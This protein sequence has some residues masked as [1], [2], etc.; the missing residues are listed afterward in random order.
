MKNF[1]SKIVKRMNTS[2]TRWFEILK[3]KGIGP[4]SMIVLICLGTSAFLGA[5]VP[6][7]I[8]ELSRTYDD[9][10]LFKQSLINLSIIFFAVYAN[11]A[12]YQIGVNKFIKL[13]VRRVRNFCYQKWLLHYD[14]QSS[15]DK[16]TEAFPQGE[17]LAR[18][19]NDTES[20]RELIT[21][22]TFGIFIDLFF[23]ISCLVSFLKINLIS[24]GFLMVVEVLA[25]II[26]I[27]LSK[28]MRA[29]F[30]S[31]RNARGY[32]SRAVANV[33]G[34]ISETHY[35]DHQ[36]YASK[37]CEKRFTDF[38]NKQLVSN[39]WDAGYYS[40]AES[41]YPMLLACVVFIFPYSKITEVAV[42][43]AIVD[44]IQRSIGPIKDI[45]GKIANVQR[46]MT[47]FQRIG[48]FINH[49]EEGFFSE[50]RSALGESVTFD[51]LEV[52][53]DHFQYFSTKGQSSF[54]L[55]DIHF[56]GEKGELIGLVGLSGS[57]KSTLLNILAANIIPDKADIRLLSGDKSSVHSYPGS[58]AMDVVRYREQIGIVSQE[59]HVF[60]ETLAFNITL[61]DN[62]PE[63]FEKFWSWVEEQIPYFVE[64]GIKSDTLINPSEL[65]SGQKQLIAAVRS[66]YLKKTIVLFDE[67]SSGLD[68][69][70][71]AALR[72]VVLLVQQNSLTIIVAHRVETIID[73]DKIL[74][75]DDG[76]LVSMGRHHDLLQSSQTYAQFLHE[77]SPSEAN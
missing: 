9:L 24:G 62:I 25:S 67:I 58:G 55:S 42:I 28:Y 35:T 74:V 53:I 6:G 2:L 54:S 48:G 27:W 21:S 75:M 61:S 4:L 34:G 14:V 63:D 72:K 38:L 23:V 50:K 18:I 19:M 37:N 71:E 68:G 17:V 32:M 59:S 69:A 66:C 10:D 12:I 64:W 44:L 8:A 26:L 5:K 76:K 49:L 46:A 3:F 30:L 15:K 22:G 77:L 1:F 16:K 41:L 33:V 20:F 39:V 73:A 51:Q 43:F 56:V 40:L 29:I 52:N 31:V 13:L 65:S 60:S 70:L 11:R 47:G 45:A 36:M 7:M 57:G